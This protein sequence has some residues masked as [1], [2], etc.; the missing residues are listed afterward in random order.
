MVLNEKFEDEVIKN[1]FSERLIE[2][3]VSKYFIPKFIRFQYVKLNKESRVHKSVISKLL[4]HGIDPDT[5]L[6]DCLHPTS[7]TKEKDKEKEKDKVSYISSSEKFDP[8]KHLDVKK[9]LSEVTTQEDLKRFTP[10]HV[11]DLWNEI[12]GDRLSRASTLGGGKHRD[13]F[14]KSLEFL[15]TEKHWRDLFEQCLN[16]PRLMGQNDINWAVS[17]VWIVD[18]DNAIKVL[19]GDFAEDKLVKNLF[20]SMKPEASA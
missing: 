1:N 5:L 4:D 20:A 7:S 16:I 9:I 19:N 14:L 2:I 15:P 10:D 17:L 11:V 13:N 3:G 18:F 8:S 12:F 6:I